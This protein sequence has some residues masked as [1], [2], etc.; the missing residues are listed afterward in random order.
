MT[1]T[2]TAALS[3]IEPAPDPLDLESWAA[4]T[5]PPGHYFDPVA[6]AKAEAF[7]PRYLRHTKG[8]WAGQPFVLEGWQRGV[9]RTAFGWK[10]ADG[11]RRFRTVYILVPRK[12]GKTG[13]AAGIALY[14]ML[15]DGEIGAEVY[16]FASDTDQAAICH[17]EA[18][19]MVRQ[20]PQL[21]GRCIVRTKSIAA[22]KTASAYK[23]L[24]STSGTKDGLNAHGT[25]GDELHAV[26]DRALYD[27]LHTSSG[28]RTQP[29]EWLI[30]TQGV[31]LASLQGEIDDHAAKVFSGEIEDPEFL[32]VRYFLPADVD[33]KDPA[34]WQRAN[35]SLGTTFGPD[36]LADRIKEAVNF[37]AR[38]NTIKR[39]HFNIRTEQVT[40]WLP[41]DLWKQS[42]I[43]APVTLQSL[44]GREVW[45][46]LDLSSTTDLTA[47]CL[48]A[49][50][51]DGGFDAWWR[52]WMPSGTLTSG[53]P[54]DAFL[55][56][57]TRRDG[58]DYARAVR[59]GWI[60]C[61]DGNV[62]DYDRIR[63]AITGQVGTGQPAHNGG[64]PLDDEP[65]IVDL[66]NLRELAIDRW[67]ATQITTQLTG[68]GVTVVPFGQGF[69]SMSAPAKALEALVRGQTLNHGGNPVATW[70]AGNVAVETDAAENIKP[71]KDPKRGSRKRIDGI[72]A[73]I[74]AL[75]RAGV[76]QPAEES[77]TAA[78]Q[79]VVVG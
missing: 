34:N 13:L 65:P 18:K 52:F 70:M 27:L 36:Y 15:A 28:A 68:D 74:M 32:P 5:A 66:V 44:A 19:L 25:V 30:T 23:V 62:V 2:S 40:A 57:R 60:T 76:A 75:G 38:E 67:N 21:S 53:T 71:S 77:M 58:F 41:L 33:W 42:P 61:T 31:D 35:P 17:N 69:A 37:P 55:R 72:V 43:V 39:L 10:R 22:L 4:R 1:T 64:P 3:S 7:F 46:A 54:S 59:E 20:H 78:G 49:R 8:R 50:R 48:V 14:L 9:V 29:L 47:L 79:I 26:K 11:T 6:A 63:K 24:S 45:G 16:S 51:G 56:E 73:L 12:N